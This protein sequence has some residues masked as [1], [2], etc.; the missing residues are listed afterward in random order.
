MSVK[1]PA[2]LRISFKQE[3]NAESLIHYNEYMIS[4]SQLQVQ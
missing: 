1:N 2:L 4:I 3:C